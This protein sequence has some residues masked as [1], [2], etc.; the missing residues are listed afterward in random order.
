MKILQSAEGHVEHSADRTVSNLQLPG[1]PV[2]NKQ[3]GKGAGGTKEIYAESHTTHTPVYRMELAPPRIY[4]FFKKHQKKLYLVYTQRPNG[5][6]KNLE[7]E[8]PIH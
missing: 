3:W 2:Y 5:K 1:K 8:N 4:Y 6:G 7:P